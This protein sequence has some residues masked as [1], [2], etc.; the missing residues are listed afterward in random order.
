MDRRTSFAALAAA[1]ALFPSGAKGQA[2]P[3]GESVNIVDWGAHADGKVDATGAIRAA[4][5]HWRRQ[6]M[7]ELVIP[8]GEF[9]IK[10]TVRFDHPWGG[11]LRCIGRLAT[12]ITGRT[13][14]QI[15]PDDG[16]AV[17]ITVIGLKV[18][19]R[20]MDMDQRHR[21]SGSIGIELRNLVCSSVE[22]VECTNFATNIL[23]IGTQANGGF[24]YNR[25]D[26]GYIRDCVRS[27]VL[28]AA[29][30][31]YCNENNFYGGS[32]SRSSNYPLPP[33]AVHIEIAHRQVDALNN[34]RFWGPSFE[35]LY[36]GARAAVINGA[37]NAII[38][39]RMENPGDQAGYLIHFTRNSLRCELEPGFMIHHSNI[40]DEGLANSW[41]T[42][43][44]AVERADTPDAPGHAVRTFQSRATSF[45]RLIRGLD[46]GG[47]ER[48]SIDGQG[49]AHFARHA[50]VGD[51]LR[52][53]SSD[54]SN[55]DRGIFT[56]EGAPEGKVAAAPGSLYVN[57]NGGA[58]ATLWVKEA[59]KGK[60]GWA[61]K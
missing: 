49:I 57:L 43:Q 29:G 27:L 39:P 40:R 11:T 37:N 36:P 3:K 6:P 1:G 26:L 50:Y 13:A 45:A 52:Y 7:A 59:G 34:N 35:D 42:V 55:I 25:V 24:S 41:R 8:A 12:D 51:G 17:G 58:G 21:S 33:D 18:R 48:W 2:A 61:A 15:G 20:V 4:V 53:A 54:G 14:I 23:C 19:R 28:D 5:A 9:L 46:S 56:G 31:G 60:S 44:G 32:F 10:D 30:S 38:R 16:P 47:V 22:I